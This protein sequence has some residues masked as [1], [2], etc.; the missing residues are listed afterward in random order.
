MK[1][2]FH[3]FHIPHYGYYTGYIKKSAALV[4]EIHALTYKIILKVVSWECLW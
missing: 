2:Y 1:V 3:V 4:V